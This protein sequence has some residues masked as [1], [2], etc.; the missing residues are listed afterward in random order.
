MKTENIKTKEQF[1]ELFESS[2]AAFIAT[3]IELTHKTYEVKVKNPSGV[4]ENITMHN[5]SAEHMNDLVD[6][7]LCYGMEVSVKGEW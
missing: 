1:E 4:Y 2:R 7:M 6:I 5:V 3:P